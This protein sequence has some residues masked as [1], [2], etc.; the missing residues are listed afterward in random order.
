VPEGGRDGDAARTEGQ[1]V[2]VVGF[3]NERATSIARSTLSA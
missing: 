2:G 1:N 3:D